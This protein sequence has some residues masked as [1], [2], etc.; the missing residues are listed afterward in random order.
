MGAEA[1]ASQGVQREGQG[2]GYLEGVQDAGQKGQLV[3]G[4]VAQIKVSG[5]EDSS[6]VP[7][8]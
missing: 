3:L 5:L 7:T 4:A 2:G 6:G 8:V 1:G